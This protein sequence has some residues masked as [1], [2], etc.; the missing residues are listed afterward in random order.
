MCCGFASNDNI[1]MFDAD[2]NWTDLTWGL[3][4][5]LDCQS[6]YL[7]KDSKSCS[8]SHHSQIGNCASYIPSASSMTA[9]KHQMI[10]PSSQV[11]CRD[12]YPNPLAPA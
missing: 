4:L 10:I 5:Y 9:S 12:G 6:S 1:E 7:D 11:G 8:S 2:A 3:S